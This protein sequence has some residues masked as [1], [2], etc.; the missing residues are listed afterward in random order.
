MMTP[1]MIAPV[2]HIKATHF[3]R[4]A[5]C[6]GVIPLPFASDAMKKLFGVSL[7]HRQ[8]KSSVLPLMM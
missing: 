4:S 3:L 2:K 8:N 1:Y 6:R 7:L 5:L